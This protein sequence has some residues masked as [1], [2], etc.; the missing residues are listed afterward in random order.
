MLLIRLNV[1]NITF[2][3][4]NIIPVPR[5][6]QAFHKCQLLVF[7]GLSKFFNHKF[8]MVIWLKSVS[9]IRLLESW[10][11]KPH[12]LDSLLSHQQIT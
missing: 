7:I 6:E 2:S 4:L 11:Q 1:I 10:E 5:T 12:Q 8:S 9:S 3:K